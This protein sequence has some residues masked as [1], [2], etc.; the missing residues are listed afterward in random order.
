MVVK[1]MSEPWEILSHLKKSSSYGTEELLQTIGNIETWYFLSYFLFNSFFIQF[2]FTSL[3]DALDHMIYVFWTVH[4]QELS[5]MEQCVIHVGN[6]QFMEYV[7][8]VPS[9]IIMIYAQYAII[10]ISIICVIDF[11]ESRK[12]D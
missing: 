8:N 10:L 3:T 12:E 2:F 7:G 1:D 5:M 4:Q 11:I 9:A 6:S